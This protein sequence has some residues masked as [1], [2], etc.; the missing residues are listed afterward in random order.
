MYLV[1]FEY[2][3]QNHAKRKRIYPTQEALSRIGRYCGR[4]GSQPSRMCKVALGLFEKTRTSG[5]KKIAIYGSHTI[6]V[7]KWVKRQVEQG[8]SSF[9]AKFLPYLMIFQSGVHREVLWNFEKNIK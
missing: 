3:R 2:S 9:Y 6:A 1:L 5:M 8:F 7:E 4:Q